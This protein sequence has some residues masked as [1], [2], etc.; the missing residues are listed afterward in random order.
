M[1]ER[2]RLGVAL[3]GQTDGGRVSRFALAT[4]LHKTIRIPSITDSAAIP[5][6][7]PAC[8]HSV[9]AIRGMSGR[10][11]RCAFATFHPDVMVWE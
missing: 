9:F 6:P 3:L 1:S 11:W 10:Y 2:S 5:T 4:M 8:P 7:S